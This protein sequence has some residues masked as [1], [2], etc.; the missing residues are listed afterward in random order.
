MALNYFGK[1]ISYKEMFM[2]IDRCAKALKVHGVKQGEIISMSLPNTPEAVYLFYAISKVGAI[3]NM[4]DP[5]TN[6]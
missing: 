3:A 1:K 6:S 2:H 4:I 5:R